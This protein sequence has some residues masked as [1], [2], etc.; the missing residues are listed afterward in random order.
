MISRLRRI[1]GTAIAVVA[2]AGVFGFSTAAAEVP[3]PP[4]SGAIVDLTASLPAQDLRSI[5]AD[6]RAFA[7][8]RGSQVAVLLVPSTKPESIEQYSLRVAEAWKIG[9]AKVD[10]GVILVVAKDDRSLRLEVGYG[11]EGAIPDAIA[12]RVISETIAPRFR[13]GEFAAGIR[14]GTGTLMKL[15]EGE[16]LPEPA[17][18]HT[19]TNAFG[20]SDLFVPLIVAAA[21]GSV[22]MS[23][24]GKLPGAALAGAGFGVAA[25]WMLG[26]VFVG[27]A[28]AFVGFLFSLLG[29]ASRG[30]HIGGGGGWG[31]GGGWGNGGSGGGFGG[32]G[33]GFGGGGASGRW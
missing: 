26:S 12:K 31:S 1:V 3:V 16:H 17:F 27:L 23:M 19:D 11:L 15:I 33:G 14:E 9:R 7:A 32:G 13:N 20:V 8:R 28:A 10:D 29:S 6:L 2:G 24:F 18:T 22:L 30:R 25:W 21:A 4:L 5:D